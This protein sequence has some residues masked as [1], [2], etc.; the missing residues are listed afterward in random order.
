MF[1]AWRRTCLNSGCLFKA[2]EAR[3]LGSS[4]GFA[5]DH[6]LPPRLI[7]DMELLVFISKGINGLKMILLLEVLGDTFLIPS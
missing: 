7:K 1:S 3:H 5:I 6:R 4:K 2:L